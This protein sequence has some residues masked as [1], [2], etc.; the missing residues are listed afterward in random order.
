MV[1][2]VE[3]DLAGVATRDEHQLKVSGVAVDLGDT[4]VMTPFHTVVSAEQ[5]LKYTHGQCGF[6]PILTTRRDQFMSEDTTPTLSDF[7]DST[8][9]DG[10]SDVEQQVE[11]NAE[12]IEYLISA[13]EQLNASLDEKLS[14]VEADRDGVADGPAAELGE[15]AEEMYQ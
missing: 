1:D 9:V 10:D 14:S 6:N 11:E 15:R 8:G 2:V 4:H 5:S 7:V 3:G 13:I 12:N